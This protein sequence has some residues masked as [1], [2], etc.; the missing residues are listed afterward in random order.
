M[1]GIVKENSLL[2]SGKKG[3]HDRYFFKQKM[4]RQSPT[5]TRG[6]GERD[7][8]LSST[9]HVERPAQGALLSDTAALGAGYPVGCAHSHTSADST[10]ATS[11][12]NT[13]VGNLDL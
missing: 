4:R 1:T 7:T 10:S 9:A 6:T 5:H 11:E 13:Y 2:I 8:T 3:K 12:Q